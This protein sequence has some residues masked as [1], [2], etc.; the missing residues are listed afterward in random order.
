MTK[1]ELNNWKKGFKTGDKVRINIPSSKYHGMEGTV[2]HKTSYVFVDLDDDNQI[3]LRTGLEIIEAAAPEP[4]APKKELTLK[5]GDWVSLHNSDVFE[6]HRKVGFW[7]KNRSFRVS[8]VTKSSY[9]L[10]LPAIKGCKDG[11]F[12]NAQVALGVFNNVHG[13]IPTHNYQDDVEFYIPFESNEKHFE[14]ISLP[15]RF[16]VT[17]YGHHPKQT[18]TSKQGFHY[19]YQMS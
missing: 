18:D 1:Q 2:S 8:K 12:H 13:N 16:G 6:L 9:W 4:K 15:T 3:G 11:I 14:F 10:E 17:K 19:E 7:M 5:V